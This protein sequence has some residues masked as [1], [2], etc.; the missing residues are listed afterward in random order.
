MILTL[1]QENFRRV[2]PENEIADHIPQGKKQTNSHLA[3]NK[4]LR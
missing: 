4:S 3:K 1:A 2:S